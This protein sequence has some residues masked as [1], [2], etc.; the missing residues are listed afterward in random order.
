VSGPAGSG[1]AAGHGATVVDVEEAVV[2]DDVDVEPLVEVV[3]ETADVAELPPSS[4]PHAARSTTA[5]SGTTK[6]AVAVR[7]TTAS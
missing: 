3:V 4:L 7:R 2:A 6:R 1:G 5:T